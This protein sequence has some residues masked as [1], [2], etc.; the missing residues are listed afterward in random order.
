[1]GMGFKVPN[2]ARL[3]SMAIAFVCI[4]MCCQQHFM[5]KMWTPVMDM[6]GFDMARSM[7]VVIFL[8]VMLDHALG[9]NNDHQAFWICCLFAANAGCNAN[10]VTEVC[11][12]YFTTYLLG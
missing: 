5:S 8:T 4:Y 3:I 2:T 10:I 1:M 11:W 6:L 9:N 12:L 7:F